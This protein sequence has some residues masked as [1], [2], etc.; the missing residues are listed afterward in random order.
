MYDQGSPQPI[1]IS[2]MVAYMTTQAL[3]DDVEFLADT[4]HYV[5]LLDRRFMEHARKEAERKQRVARQRQRK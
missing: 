4:T 3:A 2:E 1:Q 5:M